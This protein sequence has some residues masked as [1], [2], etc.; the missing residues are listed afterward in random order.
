MKQQKIKTAE[1]PFACTSDSMSI[2]LTAEDEYNRIKDTNLL[3]PL[4]YS[5]E[6]GDELILIDAYR[7]KKLNKKTGLPIEVRAFFK[8]K[9]KT[10]GGTKRTYSEDGTTVSKNESL[11]HQLG[12]ACFTENRLF[13]IRGLQVRNLLNDYNKDLVSYYTLLDDSEFIVTK[14]ETEVT[15]ELKDIAGN[16]VIKQP[17]ILLRCYHLGTD[18]YFDL[19]VEIAVTHKKSDEDIKLFRLNNLNVL[20]IDLSSL[21]KISNNISDAEI[22]GAITPKKFL[23]ILNGTVLGDLSKQKWLSNKLH[24]KYCSD[25]RCISVK[26]IRKCMERNSNQEGYLEDKCRHD[27]YRLNKVTIVNYTCFRCKNFVNTIGDYNYIKD[28]GKVNCEKTPYVVCTP[29]RGLINPV[30]FEVNV[31]SGYNNMT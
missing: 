24:N 9:E 19:Y 3:K 25:I 30:T 28:A 15:I 13:R 22:E 16:K 23:H 20:E 26:P 7:K 21:I 1:Y 18:S 17:D 5:Y 2:P 10:K 12:K 11:L 4:Y 29:N 14:V 8:K 27:S 6:T 31:T